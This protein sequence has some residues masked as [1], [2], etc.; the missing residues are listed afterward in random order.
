MVNYW[1]KYT[2]MHG[3]QNVKISYMFRPKRL[4]LGF[5]WAYMYARRPQFAI[6]LIFLVT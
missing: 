4:L 3:Q 6:V 5:M 1:D 2:E